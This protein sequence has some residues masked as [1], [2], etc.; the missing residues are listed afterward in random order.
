[1]D[2]TDAK[3]V[4][5]LQRDGRQ[6]LADLSETVGLSAPPHCPAGGKRR[7]HRLLGAG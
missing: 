6:R 2:A 5:A 7:D 4:Q 3:I 1:M